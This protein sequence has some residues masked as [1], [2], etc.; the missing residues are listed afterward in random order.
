MDD[1]ETVAFCP[2]DAAA[3]VDLSDEAGWNQ[4]RADWEMMLRA[5][6]STGA[7]GPDGTPEASALALPMEGGI[8]WI[9]MVLVT[10][11]K[12]RR[13][14]AQRLVSQC[15]RWLEA[16]GL[17]PVLDATP[18]GQPLY[19]SKGFSPLCGVTRMTGRGGGQDPKGLERVGTGDLGWI[20]ALDRAVFGAG[21]APILRDLIERQE[22]GALAF[23]RDGFVLGRSGRNA[24]QIGPIV[25]PDGPTALRLLQGALAQVEGPVLI[26][27]M[28]AQPAIAAYLAELGFDSQRRFQRMAKG[29]SRNFSDPSRLFAAAGPELG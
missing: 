27:T 1:T 24:T 3:C 5:G 28:D 25:A 4:T 13:G 8:G 9:S 26:D 15:V 21:R 23:G 6:W 14:I 29:I 20:E 19:S 2:D 11:S 17:T 12:R 10:A 16:Q 22:R 18:A 7:R